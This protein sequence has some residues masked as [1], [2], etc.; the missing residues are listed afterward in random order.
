MIKSRI[1]DKLDYTLLTPTASNSDIERFC[2]ETIDYGFKTVFVNPH[3][4]KQAYNYLAD[5]HVKVGAPIGFSLGGMKTAI[6][7]AETKLAIEDGASE[8]DMLINLGA[9]KS[10]EYNIVKRDISEVVKASEGC[11]TKVIIETGLLTGEEKCIATELVKE[12]GADFVKTA[13]GFNGGGATIEDVKL[14]RSI[15]GPQ[16]GVK[17]AGGIRSLKEAEAM[18]EAGANRIGT[19]SAV[20][21][22]NGGYSDKTY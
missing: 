19:S 14:L 11:L 1:I 13:T 4:I 5:H 8:I 17:A 21:I 16:M 10:K 18:I 2:N 6:K 15:V 3:Y 9:L 20:L 7:V 12:A 22:V